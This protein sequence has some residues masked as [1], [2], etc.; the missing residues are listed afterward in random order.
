MDSHHRYRQGLQKI[1]SFL[2]KADITEFLPRGPGR[3]R[4]DWREREGAG[5]WGV[6]GR[7]DRESE[8][9]RKGEGEGGKKR[10]G[11]LAGDGW[12]GGQTHTDT[13]A[14]GWSSRREYT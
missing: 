4:C 10:E 14:L 8:R 3:P 13:T 9:Q 12:T 2:R 1:H 5:V 7:K 11:M 6:R